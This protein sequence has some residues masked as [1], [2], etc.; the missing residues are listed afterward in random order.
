MPA[1]NFRSHHEMRQKT[2]LK[3]V[4]A[5]R[6]GV[7]SKRGIQ[8]HSGLSW[9]SC[10]PVINHLLSQKVIVTQEVVNDGKLSKGRKTKFFN[11]NKERFLLM[12]MEINRTS[13]SCCVTTLGGENLGSYSSAFSQALNSTNISRSVTEAYLDAGD[14]LGLDPKNIICISFSLTGAIDAGKNVW[15]SSARIPDVEG[16]DF[17][18]LNGKNLLPEDIYI[19]HDVHAQAYSVIP[20]SELRDSDFVFYR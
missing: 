13:I 15:H 20:A 19:Q 1:K 11:F 18:S 5:L 2:Y 17:N 14:K 6:E 4:N 8:D 9:G 3:I 7:N 12:G 10:S 16:I